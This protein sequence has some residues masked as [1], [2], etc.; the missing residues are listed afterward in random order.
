MNMNSEGGLY[1]RLVKTRENCSCMGWPKERGNGDS[2]KKIHRQN[3]RELLLYGN[4]NA[5]SCTREKRFCYTNK[6]IC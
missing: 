4:Q 1:V 2:A 3:E 6:V 5:Q